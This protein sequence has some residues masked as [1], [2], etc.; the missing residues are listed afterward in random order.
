MTFVNEFAFWSRQ[1][2]FCLNFQLEALIVSVCLCGL[3][4]GRGPS[5][6]HRDGWMG[7]P[8]YPSQVWAAP[9]GA[10]AGKV[11]DFVPNTLP[12]C[13]SSCCGPRAES[14]DREWACRAKGLLRLSAAFSHS[15]LSLKVWQ[16]PSVLEKLEFQQG[17]DRGKTVM[18]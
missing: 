13:Q 18:V 6:R 2:Y 16:E 4:G 8:G 14:C 11:G 7:T 15:Q 1:P 10:R 5:L 12:G 17:K 9:R 3:P